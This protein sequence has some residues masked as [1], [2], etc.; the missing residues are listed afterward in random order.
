MFLESNSPLACTGTFSEANPDV[1]SIRINASDL[2]QIQTNALIKANTR[3]Q[4]ARGC[5]PS[6]LCAEEVT[7]ENPA[8][9]WRELNGKS[10][11]PLQ[12]GNQISC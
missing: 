10:R 5:N 2:R 1:E 6:F 3:L 8:D 7:L 4:D 12:L 9:S 11:N